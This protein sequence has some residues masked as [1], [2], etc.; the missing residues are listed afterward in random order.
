MQNNYPCQ[1]HLLHL[2]CDLHALPVLD[3]QVPVLHLLLVL[4]L[5]RVQMLIGQLL[6]LNSSELL[7][8]EKRVLFM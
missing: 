1:D 5:L 7:L 8:C 6:Q 4:D 2:I 3:P